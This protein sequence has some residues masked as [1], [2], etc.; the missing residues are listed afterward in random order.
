M[1]RLLETLSALK[2][3]GPSGPTQEDS[4]L[5]SYLEVLARSLLEISS[6]ESME[7]VTGYSPGGWRGAHSSLVSNPLDIAY[8][9]VYKQ[10]VINSKKCAAPLSI[11]LGGSGVPCRVGQSALKPKGYRLNNRG[12]QVLSINF[13]KELFGFHWVP[14]GSI[15]FHSVPLRSIASHWVPLGST[16]FS[17]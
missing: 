15:G 4:Q 12:K 13:D 11:A 6:R 17:A 7:I 2:S 3:R 16:F 5:S 9:S 14:L 10:G 1:P 8:V